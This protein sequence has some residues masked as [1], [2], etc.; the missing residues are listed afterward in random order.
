MRHLCKYS[1][2]QIL[3]K[4][5]D[6]FWTLAFPLIM[7]TLFYVS[8]WNSDSEQMKAVPAACVRGENAVFESFLEQMDGNMITV[9]WL[10]EDE[11]MAALENGEVD[12]VFF[13]EQEPCLKVSSAQ[14]NESILGM[15]LNTYNQNSR[16]VQ[17][18]LRENPLKLS[19][20]LT[21]LS[22]YQD[23]IEPVS[24]GGRAVN[25]GIT[26]FFALIG[27][28]CLFGSF[29]GMTA[30]MNLRADQSELAARRSVV[31]V[32]RL[33]MVASELACVFFVQ[34]VNV[35]LLLVY[36][37]FGLH[38]SLGPQWPLLLPVCALG[39]VAGV[40]YGVFLGSLHLGEGVKNGILVGSSLAM[41]FLA[42]LMF[43]NMKDI[44]EH[45][46]P[47]VNRIN[48]AAL[49]SD[50]FYS[51]SVYENPGRYTRSLLLLAAFAVVLTAVSVIKLGR[52]RYDSL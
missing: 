10:E 34:F 22:D 32:S 46:C 11:A 19:G 15:L 29:P 47:L 20:T 8:F 13:A 45:A 33:P 40:S 4:R 31:P 5:D 12:G 7:A 36:L 43:G 27:M 48:P 28:A 1:L 3:R 51:I 21:A 37:N 16:L 41:S 35:C 2:L 49:I 6:L 25:N 17:D 14:L 26:Y 39:S 9:R 24:A 18:V 42:G 30:A 23:M 44:I 38:I 50:A 52:E